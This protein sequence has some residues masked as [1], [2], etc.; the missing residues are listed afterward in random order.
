MF[1]FSQKFLGRIE[2][3]RTRLEGKNMAKIFTQAQR[4]NAQTFSTKTQAKIFI[5]PRPASNQDC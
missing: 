2:S 5:I 4:S 3:D 1:D